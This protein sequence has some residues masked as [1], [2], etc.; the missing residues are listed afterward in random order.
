MPTV[1]KLNSLS[2]LPRVYKNSKRAWTDN[3]IETLKSL[4]S[5]GHSY[6]RIG[7]DMGRTKAAVQT[8]A[9][10]ER[11]INRGGGQKDPPHSFEALKTTQEVLKSL[12]YRLA[13]TKLEQ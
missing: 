13:I 7:R 5:Q 2:E 12:G 1:T 9:S 11:L 6:K 4:L 8:K 3:E 10:V